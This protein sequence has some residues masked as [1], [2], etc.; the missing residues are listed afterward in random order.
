[1]KRLTAA[2]PEGKGQYNK[3]SQDVL[4]PAFFAAYSG[5]PVEK[6]QLSPFYS[7]PLPNWT[8]AYNGLSGLEFIKKKFSAFT[9]NHSYSST[10]SVG[11]F[12][13]NLDYGA[14]Y[15]N[16]A[17]QN[18][19]PGTIRDQTG[20]LLP[21]FAN[22]LNQYVPIVAMSTITMSEKFQPLIGVQLQTKSR[23]NGRVEY[24][25]SRDVA[26]SLS[27]SQVAEFSTKDLMVSLGFTKQ[28]VRIPFRINGAY[29]RLKNDL[30][31]T[32]NLTLRDARDVQRKL[33][34]EFTILSRSVL[35]F[36]LNPQLSYIVNRRLNFNVYFT[37]SFNDPFVS[38]VFPQATTSGG[39]R[40]KFNLAE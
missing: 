24:S 38:T 22:Q 40:V 34:A 25:Q 9:I 36:Q 4:I 13:S 35:N 21:L 17:V 5:Q 37:R 26:L 15:V 14:A 7:F 30:N 23:I 1:M 29:K 31:F 10:Y 32:C 8:V 3:T 12:T 33:D 2:N 18:F 16:L 27:N 20:Q 19:A 11:N 6:A 39:V 28:N